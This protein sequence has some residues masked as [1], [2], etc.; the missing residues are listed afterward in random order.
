MVVGW[1]AWLIGFLIITLVCGAVISIVFQLAH[2]VEGTTF[3]TDADKMKK[4]EWAIDQLRSTS[5]FGTGSGFLHWMLGGLNF[6]IEHHLFPRIS[7]IHYPALGVHVRQTCI[8]YGIRYNEYK[9]MFAAIISHI[10]LLRKL[11]RVSR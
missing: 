11:G 4:Q 9:S 5:N 7:H 10:A 6:Q 1:L 2:V 3:F 8:E